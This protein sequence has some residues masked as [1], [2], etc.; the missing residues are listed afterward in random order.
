MLLLTVVYGAT[1]N[2][3]DIVQNTVFSLKTQRF[4]DWIVSPFSDGSYSVWPNR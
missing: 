4:G 2:V 3:L 1:I